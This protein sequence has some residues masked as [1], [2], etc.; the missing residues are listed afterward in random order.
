MKEKQWQEKPWISRIK[1]LKP[2]KHIVSPF[3]SV[4]FFFTSLG[5]GKRKVPYLYSDPVL[6]LLF[7]LFVFE[8]TYKII[9]IALV[10]GHTPIFLFG[11]R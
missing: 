6:M 4:L 9:I 8:K 7:Y 2:K 1:S 3:P 10:G 5:E 11:I